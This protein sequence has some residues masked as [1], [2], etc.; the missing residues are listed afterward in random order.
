MT[1]SSSPRGAVSVPREVKEGQ[2]PETV[3]RSERV[4]GRRPTATQQVDP[5]TYERIGRYRTHGC[6]GGTWSLGH[7]SVVARWALG[8]REPLSY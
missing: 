5:I 8:G 4:F 3:Q 6:S 7:R 1:T 2:W